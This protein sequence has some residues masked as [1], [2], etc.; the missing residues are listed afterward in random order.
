MTADEKRER[1]LKRIIP[2]LAIM[3]VYF[4]LLNHWVTQGTEKAEKARQGFF[5]R[6]VRLA[7]N[8][9]LVRQRGQLDAEIQR[10][11]AKKAEFGKQLNKNA[12]F[13]SDPIYASRLSDRIAS[14]LA[15]YRL[16]ETGS[17][18]P[19]DGKDTARAIQDVAGFMAPS[20]DKIVRPIIWRVNFTGF[21][22]DVYRM[23]DELGAGKPAAIPVSF[24]MK[25]AP[26]D[27]MGM[28][29]SLSFWTGIVNETARDA[30]KK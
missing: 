17:D 26:E 23:L 8:Q 4:S 29:W 14:L 2:G 12:E 25:P 3:V 1:Q 10:L 21:Y 5:D 24:S 22:A 19:S 15:K 30:K 6:G 27:R 20:P 7:A 13:L 18:N 11:T 9:A 16:R 28:A